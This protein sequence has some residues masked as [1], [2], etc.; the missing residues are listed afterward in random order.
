MGALLAI[1]TGDGWAWG[2]SGGCQLGPADPLGLQPAGWRFTDAPDP[3]SSTLEVQVSESACASG[4]TPG[5]RLLGP[6]LEE[7]ADEVRLAFFTVPPPS[8][9]TC[10]SNPTTTVTIELDEPLGAREIIDAAYHAVGLD[11]PGR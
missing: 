8:P 2:G 7:T 3:T 5:D 9:S 10:P 6:I 11:Q 1:Q 4:T